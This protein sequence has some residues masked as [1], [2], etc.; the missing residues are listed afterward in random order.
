MHIDVTDTGTGMPPDVVERLGE[1]FFTTRPGAGQGLGLVVVRAT[2]ELIGGRLDVR[3]VPG[4]GTCMT[5]V[6]PMEARP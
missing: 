1:P 2:L 5:L 4:Q 3:S 6:V